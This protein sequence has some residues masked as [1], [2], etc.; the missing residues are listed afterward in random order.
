LHKEAL[1]KAKEKG[2]MISVSGV[3]KNGVL[4]EIRPLGFCDIRKVKNSKNNYVSIDGKECM[5]VD[6]I[7]DDDNITYGRDLGILVSSSSFT[8]F[9]DDFFVESYSKARPQL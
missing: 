1:L 3:I 6:P 8:A 2:V 7:P 5:V 4:D 9:M